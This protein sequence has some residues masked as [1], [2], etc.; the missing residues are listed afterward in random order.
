MTEQ[1]VRPA[2]T[3]APP[4]VPGR[5]PTDDGGR[6]ALA[7]IA[8]RPLGVV[9]GLV[10]ALL[11]TTNSGYGYHR[12][13][14]YFLMLRPDW[15]YRDQPPLTP[16]IAR[17]A[18]TLFGGSLWGLRV[19]ATLFVL[20]ALLLAALL[21]RELGGGAL[22]QTLAALGLGTGA[23]TLIFGHV[24]LTAGP[25]LVVWL[26]IV[27]CAARA[28]LRDQPRWWLA[29]GA[30][31]GVGLYNKLLVVLLLVGL[32]A[33]LLAVGPRRVLASRWLWA[34]VALALVVGAPNLVYQFTH[35]LPQADMAG[36][37]A[38]NKGAESRST[39]VPFQ[40]LLIGPPLAAVWLAGLVGLLRR[41]PWRPVRALA[42]AYLTVCV[43]VLVS[44]GQP[45][46]TYGLLGALF[47]AGCVLLEGWLGR[48]RRRLRATLT[49]TA[50]LANV[51]ASAVIALPL[52]PV[53]MLGDSPVP[54][55]NVTAADSV[56]WPRYVDQVVR[57][58][59][60]LP[61]ADR[62]AAVVLT[63]N[64]GEAGALTRLGAD[65]LPAI[66]SGHNELGYYGPPPESATVLVG[67]GI[68]EPDELV[69]YFGGCRLAARLDN[70]VGVDNEEQG[71]PVV[72]CH[73]R[74]LSWAEM[75]PRIRHFD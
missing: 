37:I 56:G 8:W 71:V 51:L 12:D 19:P 28:L 23:A 10:A 61:P 39:F 38:D 27:L 17:L 2:A 60:E 65:R 5:S 62:A 6:A 69:R 67:V 59:D 34:G 31:L 53:G 73:Q 50:F 41:R 42:V 15:G 35:E 45:Y 21:A 4:G 46:Y 55:I 48:G 64:Y 72:V 20:A 74:R 9:A 75:W 18:D 29:A 14:L 33:G 25:D 58:Y 1:A 30:V 16:A 57:A 63:A 66:Y 3:V 26:G 36:A 32:G 52:L 40:L 24:L 44:G 70:G 54:G 68:G 43:L 13:E 11:L 49:G 47:A 7:P 22:A